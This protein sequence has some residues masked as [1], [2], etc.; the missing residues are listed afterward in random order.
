MNISKSDTTR[1]FVIYF[2]RCSLSDYMFRLF[3]LGH[4][5]VLSLY[6]GHY[7]MYDMIKYVEFITIQRDL[8][9]VYK[10]YADFVEDTIQCI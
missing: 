9:F 5:Q 8:D 2:A 1:A 3:S 10:I 6:R 4:R 7:K